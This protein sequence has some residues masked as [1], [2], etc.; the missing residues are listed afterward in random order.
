M[1]IL[2]TI[3]SLLLAAIGYYIREMSIDIKY[4]N[5]QLT[6]IAVHNAVSKERTDNIEYR[7]VELEKI[8][9]HFKPSL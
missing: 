1:E 9:K 8:F 3:A 6:E 2:I 5:K 7:I 4:I